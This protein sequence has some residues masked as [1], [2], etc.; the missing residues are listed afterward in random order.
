[1]NPSG[2]FKALLGIVLALMLVLA[3]IVG[4]LFYPQPLFGEKLELEGL[5]LYAD[6]P[7]GAEL[8]AA[9]V[10][11]LLRMSFI[12][13]LPEG[14]D[15]RVFYCRSPRRYELLARLARLH[16]K[17]QGFGLYYAGNIFVSADGLEASERLG[18]EALENTRLEGSMAHVIAHE[19]AH[20]VHVRELG[21]RDSKALPVWKSEG[22]ADWA[23]TLLVRDDAE[24]FR[25]RYEAYGDF[26]RWSRSARH[27]REFLAWQLLAEYH[28]DVRE[29]SREEFFDPSLREGELWEELVTW[30]LKGTSI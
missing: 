12:D 5:T 8:E 3:A 24:G 17:S 29:G 14:R 25:E 26:H 22:Y 7:I 13:G 4:L 1:M 16:P 27:L 19:A 28:F 20:F 30:A 9:A 2:L 10:E 6:T 18:V 15:Y 11:G 23:A 21:F